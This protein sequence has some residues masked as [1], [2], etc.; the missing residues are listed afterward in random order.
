[1]DQDQ[2]RETEG[3]FCS[4]FALK[5]SV[6]NSASLVYWSA[7]RSAS[8]VPPQIALLLDHCRTFKTL[9]EHARQCADIFA[10]SGSPNAPT[11][12]S[13]K[14]HLAALANTGLLVS[15]RAVLEACYRKPMESP[16]SIASLGVITRNRTESLERCLGSFIENSK[17]YG[18]A[19]DFVVM[20]DSE[21]SAV[22]LK[23]R[24][25]LAALKHKYDVEILYAATEEKAAFAGS[26][27]SE[28]KFDPSVVEFALIDFGDYEFSCGKNRNALLLHGIG[29]LIFSVD[30]DAVC[31]IAA[32]AESDVEHEPDRRRQPLPPVEFWFFDS[33]KETLASVSFVEEDLLELHE[34]LLG[35][36]LAD[37]FRV[38]GGIDLLSWDNSM[39]PHLRSLASGADRVLVTLSGMVGDSGMRIPPAYKPLNRSSRQ[40]LLKSKESYASA[41]SSR[42]VMRVATRYSLSNGT[43]FVSTALGYDNR[44]FLPPFFPVFRGTDGVFAATLRR[45]FEHGYVGDIPRAILHAPMQERFYDQNE[46]IH[47][48]AAVTMHS[49]II[50]C[51]MSQRTWPPLADGAKAARAIGRHLQEIGS[52]DLPEFEEFTR[53]HLWRELTGVIANLESD[54]AAH[55]DAPDCWKNDVRQCVVLIRASLTSPDLIVPQDVRC[56]R[57]LQQARSLTRELVRKFGAL[58]FEWPDIVECA[59]D[60][61]SRGRRLAVRV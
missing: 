8:I 23:N 58:L 31:K 24:A 34:Q 52:L 28:G 13:L 38:A 11:V 2:N 54:L 7:D 15:E 10:R 49:L 60:L 21:S 35:R 41:C 30:D 59:R 14:N 27:I 45:C 51:M 4:K 57:D 18:R 33:R 61:R 39:A 44:Q 53:V 56:N 43:W 17:T 9:D 32:P 20:D 19:N 1:M 40:R 3:R 12:D 46:A 29:D 42:E 37:C 5:L 26:L 36:Q 16:A 50:A 48:A 6:G 25:V 22:Q 47:D 55:K